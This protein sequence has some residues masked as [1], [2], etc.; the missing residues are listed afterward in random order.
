MFFQSLSNDLTLY[1]VSRDLIG[2]LNISDLQASINKVGGRLV[3]KAQPAR[4]VNVLF[5]VFDNGALYVQVKDGRIPHTDG[6]SYTCVS[7]N[8][9]NLELLTT[10][11]DKFKFAD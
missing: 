10:T 9:K 1:D 5:F 4:D 11:I 6:I 8:S 3:Y 7:T 2:S